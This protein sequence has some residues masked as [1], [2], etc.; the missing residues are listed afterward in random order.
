MDRTDA[1]VQRIGLSGL[2]Q[3]LLTQALTH[4]SW[5]HEH[6]GESTGHNERL[7]FLGDAVIGMVVA[8]ELYR[9]HPADDE[10]VLS[11][12]RAGIVSTAGLARI[13]ARLRIGDALRLGEGESQRGGRVRPSLMASALEAVAGAALLDLGWERATTWFIALA[14][15]ELTESPS[16]STLKSPKSQLQELTQRISGVRPEY[17][18]VDTAGPDHDR[19]FR[20]EV[21]V[22]DRVVGTG[23]GPSRRIAETQAAAEAVSALAGADPHPESATAGMQR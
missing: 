9:R 23:V 8:L 16:A 2:D 20:V 5:V 7:E 1:F 15:P 22:D 21:V 14:E 10:G 4:A 13:A 3:G 17:R 19:V 11:S 12:R 18:I 6:P